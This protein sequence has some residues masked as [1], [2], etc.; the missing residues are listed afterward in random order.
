MLAWKN[1]AKPANVHTSMSLVVKLEDDLGEH[2]DWVMLNGLFPVQTNCGFSLLTGI[3]PF[4][5]TIFNHLQMEMFLREWQDLEKDIRDDSLREAWQKIRAMAEAC[6][7]D[8]DLY[9]RFV[10]H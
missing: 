6:L 9:L 7:H 1:S 3:D 8:R 10:G 5:K 2:G 4:G